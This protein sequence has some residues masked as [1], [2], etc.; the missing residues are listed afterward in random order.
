M[1]ELFCPATAA[2][3][4]ADEPLFLFIGLT[5]GALVHAA[6]WNCAKEHEQVTA[7]HDRL[8]QDVRAELKAL[9]AAKLAAATAAAS[10][11]SS[12]GLI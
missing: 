10:S 11:S 5:I 1:H 6:L 3:L 8:M 12:S 7:Q 4:I 9:K 2:P